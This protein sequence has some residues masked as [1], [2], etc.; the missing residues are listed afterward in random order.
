[1]S[2]LAAADA[3]RQGD[4]SEDIA[5]SYW[6]VQP[7]KWTFESPKIREWAESQLSGR[8][9]N[10]CA[11]PTR[12]THPDGEEIVT[13]DMDETLDVDHHVDATEAS[14]HFG[15]EFDTVLFDPPFSSYQATTHYGGRQTG[16][17]TAMK[18]EIHEILR[19]GGRVV[20]FGYTTTCMPLA[21]GYD[22]VAVAVF[23]TLGRQKDI[24]ASV[25]RKM[26]ADISRW[27]DDC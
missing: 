14:E 23:N 12:L 18:R 7:N 26:N 13:N 27:A 1:M 3:N 9:L 10:I 21:L 11:G 22:R 6:T 15:Q 20:Q 16:Y 19:P 4:R 2:G 24:L 25:D 8:V 17:D 5:M